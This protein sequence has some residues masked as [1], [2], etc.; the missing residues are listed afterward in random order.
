[1]GAP[2]PDHLDRV[3][4]PD[5][6]VLFDARQHGVVLVAPV[7]GDLVVLALVVVGLIL[8]PALYPW[9]MLLMAA[10]VVA[11]LGWLLT[12]YLAWTHRRLM[13]T[14]HRLIV[15]QGVLTRVVR[16]IPLRRISEIRVSQ[17]IIGRMAHFG[18]I[19][20]DPSGDGRAE[21]F[22]AIH[23]PAEL[24]H[25]IYRALDVPN[26]SGSGLAAGGTGLSVAQELE[27]L[28]ELR[29]RGVISDQE[30]QAQKARLLG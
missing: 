28:D 17:G 1:M 29:Q 23:R 19:E 12:R 30:F 8:L 6:Q 2:R 10:V 3:L 16:E 7:L 20:I 27:K 18:N 21:L 24:Q 22:T 5:E 26:P 25:R 11:A 4:S 13:L 15:A 9:E 14:Q